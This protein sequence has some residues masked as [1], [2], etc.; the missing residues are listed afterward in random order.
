MDT[1]RFI[2]LKDIQV[3]KKPTYL[4]MVVADG[5]ENVNPKRVR[6]TIGGDL[7]QYDGDTSTKA[8]K[9]SACK[10]LVNNIIST[11]KAKCVTGD[12]KDFFSPNSRRIRELILFMTE[13]TSDFL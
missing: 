3:G 2:H 8:A 5:P 1:I 13:I 4:K 11:P 10:I 7:I 9:L 6:N 12:L